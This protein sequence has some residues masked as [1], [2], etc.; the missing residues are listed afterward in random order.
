MNFSELIY[1]IPSV[2]VALTVHELSHGLAAYFLGDKSVK[3]DGR[4]SLNPIRHIDP[5]GF[6]CLLVMQFGWAKPVMIDT[7]NF[8][9]PKNDMAITAFSGPLSN[10]LLAMVCFL[11]TTPL[12]IL[13]AGSSPIVVHLYVF[14]LY[15]IR[16]NIILAVFNM[17]PFPPLDGS[18]VFG[19]ALPD[20]LY[21]KM[22]SADRIGFIILMIMIITGAF[23]TIFSPIIQALHNA[24]SSFAQAIYSFL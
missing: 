23:G 14:L 20:R 9:D 7:R 1:W 16:I 17:L 8:K 6:I 3:D 13:Y 24:M 11:I 22:M 2:I 12:E 15:L 5:I 18:K 10:L 4:L 19:V 21:F